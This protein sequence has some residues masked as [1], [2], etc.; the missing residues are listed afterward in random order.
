MQGCCSEK[1]TDH[2]RKRIYD[3]TGYYVKVPQ[4]IVI[5]K[6]SKIRKQVS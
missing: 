6:P 1:C 4:P 3:G 5:K 2:P